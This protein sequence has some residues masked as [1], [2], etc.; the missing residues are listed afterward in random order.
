MTQ[1]ETHDHHVEALRRWGPL[2]VSR[3][4]TRA[5]YHVK[6]T[7]RIALALEADGRVHVVGYLRRGGRGRAVHL[8]G[9]VGL[10][11]A[12]PTTRERL[13]AVLQAEGPATATELGQAVGVHRR[14]ATHHLRVL[15]AEGKAAAPTTRYGA[16][17]GRPAEVWVAVD[18]CAAR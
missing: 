16:R 11:Q 13:L 12:Q 8:Y 17:G 18:A 3:W 2:P 9:L 1:A 15:R 7:A 6:T 10:H 14:T 4:A 5:G